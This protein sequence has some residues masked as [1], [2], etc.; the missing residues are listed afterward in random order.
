MMQ[1]LAS[2]VHGPSFTRHAN[3]LVGVGVVR[4]ILCAGAGGGIVVLA[5]LGGA[6]AAVVVGT[7]GGAGVGVPGQIFQ[8]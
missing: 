8:P 2:L 6:G 5:S 3:R 4:S 7:P 1:P